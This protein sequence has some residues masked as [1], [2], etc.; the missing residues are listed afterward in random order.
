[1]IQQETLRQNAQQGVFVTSDQQ[2]GGGR[3]A[4][5]SELCLAPSKTGPWG[6]CTGAGEWEGGPAGGGLVASALGRQE[7]DP[8]VFRGIRLTR[9]GFPPPIPSPTA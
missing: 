3:A 8:S 4:G 5:S 6:R 7:G 2:P 9:G 1:M